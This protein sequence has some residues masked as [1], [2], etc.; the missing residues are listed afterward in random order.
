MQQIAR[1]GY[2]D[3]EILDQLHFRYGSNEIKF[4]YE[5]LDKFERR[6]FTLK[7]VIDA[8]ISM[9]AFAE[10]KRTARFKIKEGEDVDWLNDRIQP[11]FLLKM[12]DGKWVEWSLGI[13]ILSSPN[14]SVANG[15]VFREIEAYD[16]LI[17][18]KDDKFLSRY[19][20]AEGT[21]YITAIND[22]LSSSGITKINIENNDANL[23][24]AKEFEP[25]TEKLKAANDL[26]TEINWTT[27]WVDEQGYY[28]SSRYRS[29]ADRPSEYDYFDNEISIIASDME[30]ELDL[31]NVANSWVVVASNPEEEPLTA[32]Y[33][34]E[35]PDSPT[36]TINR[37]RTIVDYREIESIANQ[38]ALN[39]YVERLA[40]NAS[41]V[42]G[43][44][45]FET[46]LNPLH[47]FSDVYNVRYSKLGI[48]DK[49]GETNWTMPLKAG[50][51]MSHQARKVINI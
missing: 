4:R 26:L 27:L 31:V 51:K 11:Y 14:R 7:N 37:G 49:Y 47:S 50:A 42:F 33:T 22:I 36:S 12:P 19:T 48:D 35:N 43:Y 46:A 28:T 1:E 23:K 17:I 8:E 38:I 2:T 32:N 44:I 3:K 34:N 20:I 5:L 13:F 24:R 9:A 40:F 6:K 45:T 29:P 10:I 21:N 39:N 18:L 30:E 41:Q 16:G 25:G 15:I